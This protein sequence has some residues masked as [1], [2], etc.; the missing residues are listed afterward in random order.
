MV[1]DSFDVVNEAY[2]S[3]SYSIPIGFAIKVYE[4][5]AR[6]ALQ[7]KDLNEYNQCQ[8]QLI[9]L[10]DINRKSLDEDAARKCLSSEYEFVAYRILYYIFLQYNKTS[11]HGSSDL[12]YVLSKV[13]G[14]AEAKKYVNL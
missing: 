1:R 14:N 13:T 8:T 2:S 9:Q 4:F 12:I 3:R 7:C 11:S 6:V 5:H 10:Y